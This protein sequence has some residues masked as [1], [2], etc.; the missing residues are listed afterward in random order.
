MGPHWLPVAAQD[1][2]EVETGDPP[3]GPPGLLQVRGELF[4]RV[5]DPSPFRDEGIAHEE[6]LLFRI[7][8][9]DASR[10]MAGGVDAG[11]AAKGVPVPEQDIGADRCPAEEGLHQPDEERSGPLREGHGLLPGEVR[12]IPLMDRHLCPGHPPEC[13][14]IPHMVHVVMGQEYRMNL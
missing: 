5:L 8:E 3:E 7:M 14:E 1:D 2:L 10:R 13:R 11:E 9:A 6:D 12:C 4:R